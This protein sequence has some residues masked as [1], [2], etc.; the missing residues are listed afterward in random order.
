MMSQQISREQLVQHLVKTLSDS[1]RFILWRITKGQDVVYAK[2]TKS[3]QQLFENG[4][5]LSEN[6][7]VG[8]LTE[9]PAVNA[10]VAFGDG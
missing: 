5:V 9:F 7:N 4:L 6:H 10:N 3:V 1:A 8:T 2:P